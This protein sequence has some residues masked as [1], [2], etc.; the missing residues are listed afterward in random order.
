MG[1]PSELI[2][3]IATVPPGPWAVG[4][5]GGAD[6][7]ALLALLS[8][9]RDLSLQVVHL[10][11]QTRAG[12]SE[13]D[14]EFVARLAA[15]W[16]QPCTVA[17]RDQ[18]EPLL[19]DLPANPSARYRAVRFA[20][21]RKVVE[22]NG[23]QGVILAH[24]AND[25]A[26]TV[27]HRLLRTSGDAGLTGMSG[28]VAIGGLVVLRPLLA[29]EQT[30]LTAY[31]ESEGLSW[32]TDAS[33]ESPEYFRNRLRKLITPNPPLRAALCELAN[34]LAALRDWSREAAPVLEERFAAAQLAS[35]P[36]ILAH[37]SARRWLIDRG[38]PMDEISTE[39]VDRLVDIARDAATPSRQDFPGPL[40]VRRRRGMIDV[41]HG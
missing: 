8:K 19:A 23:L 41:D 20:L 39:V 31:L 32:R 33:N 9:R 36:A 24:H 6:S 18:I 37:E 34:R 17:R 3:A 30:K 25:Q 26:E 12:E 15:Q 35:L 14:A 13:A 28:R 22:E 10:D 11:H 1:I 38:V 7:V 16:S 4:V 21:F 27:L 40:R 29:V 5:S 2:D